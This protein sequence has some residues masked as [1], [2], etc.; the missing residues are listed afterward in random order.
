MYATIDVILSKALFDDD[1]TKLPYFK[2][3]TCYLHQFSS[4]KW[5]QINKSN[6][7]QYYFFSSSSALLLWI[8]KAKKNRFVAGDVFEDSFVVLV[9]IQMF[10]LMKNHHPSTLDK[11]LL[12]INLFIYLFTHSFCTQN[13][14][15]FSHE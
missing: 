1:M 14:Y 3:I 13:T 7:F 6:T 12:P 15:T 11:S 4:L 8:Q 5:N 2:Y 10:I 9:Y